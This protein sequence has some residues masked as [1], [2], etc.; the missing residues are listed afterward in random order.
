LYSLSNPKSRSWVLKE[1]A[2]PRTDV[3]DR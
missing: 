2:Y 1:Y 3:I